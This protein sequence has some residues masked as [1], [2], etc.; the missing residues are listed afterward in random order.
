MENKIVEENENFMEI[1]EN[2]KGK[3]F[4]LAGIINRAVSNVVCSITFGRTFSHD[5][6]GFAQAVEI[7]GEEIGNPHA[8]IVDMLPFLRYVPGDFFNIKRSFKNKALLEQAAKEEIEEHRKTL[9]ENDARDFIDA[10][11]IEV[12][13]HK[14]EEATDHGFEG[15]SVCCILN[16][17]DSMDR[18]LGFS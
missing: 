18:F 4:S 6:E 1:L 5:N 13:K 7:V 2:H 15:I 9:D 16:T 14:R 17:H 3:P 11:L 10:F 8:G 12:E